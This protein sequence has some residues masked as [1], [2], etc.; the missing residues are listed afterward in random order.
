LH[1]PISHSPSI[2]LQQR[3][4]PYKPVRHVNTLLYPPPSAF[5]QHYNLP[6]PVLPNQM[7]YQPLGKRNEYRTGIV[8]EFLHR[9]S[10]YQHH[11]APQMLPNPYPHAQQPRGHY[12]LPPATRPGVS[13][14]GQY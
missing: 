10:L 9:P 1:T 6:N 14:Q 13:Y 12:Q 2:Y 7:H 4:S 8:P 5:L 11:P 3:N